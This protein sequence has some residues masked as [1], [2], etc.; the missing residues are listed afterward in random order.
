MI[1]GASVTIVLLTTDNFITDVLFEQ[2][3]ISTAVLLGEHSRQRTVMDTS[4]SDIIEA[5]ATIDAE[6]MSLS[7][8]VSIICKKS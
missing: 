4:L 5:H 3:L 2:F 6:C 7:Q 8:S 1:V